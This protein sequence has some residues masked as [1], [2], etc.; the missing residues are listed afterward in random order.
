MTTVIPSIIFNKIIEILSA[1][2]RVALKKTVRYF[3]IIQ[4]IA[5][6]VRKCDNFVNQAPRNNSKHYAKCDHDVT[7]NTYDMS[8]ATA[9][10]P[11]RSSLA[12]RMTN[13]DNDKSMDGM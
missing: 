6:L 3:Y 4:Y 12:A 10:R 2:K 11:S 7:H 9:S 5:S 1:G 13:D 8:N